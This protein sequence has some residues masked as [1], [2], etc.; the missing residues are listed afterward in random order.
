MTIL[1]FGR[2]CMFTSFADAMVDSIA[3]DLPQA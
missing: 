1:R 3:D 2:A